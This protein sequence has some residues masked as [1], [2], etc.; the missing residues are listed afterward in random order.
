M[1]ASQ[2]YSKMSRNHL[3]GNEYT[4]QALEMIGYLVLL[5]IMVIYISIKRVSMATTLN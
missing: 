1:V 3:I 2:K 4:N 5:G